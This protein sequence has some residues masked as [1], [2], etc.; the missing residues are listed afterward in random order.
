MFFKLQ[1]Y[2]TPPPEVGGK[3]DSYS[4]IESIIN[5]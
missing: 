3:T 4:N 2:V 1:V 5:I